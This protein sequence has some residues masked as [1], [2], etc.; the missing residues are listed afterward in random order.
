VSDFKRD[1]PDPQF[2][3]DADAVSVAWPCL[4]ACKD[5]IRN[6]AIVTANGIAL[7]AAL[8]YRP[9]A[10]EAT[11]ELAVSEAMNWLQVHGF[12]VERVARG[13][14]QPGLTLSR[15]ANSLDD[16]EQF[17]RSARQS[18]IDPSFLHPALLTAPLKNFISGEFDTAIYQ[19]FKAVEKSV[20][21]SSG[22]PP[23][24]YGS[25]MIE[26]AFKPKLGPLANTSLDEQE[27]RGEQSLMVGAFKRYRNASGH[28][29]SGIDDIV[30]V[31]EILALASLCL[32]IIDRNAALRRPSP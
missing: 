18:Y 32:R 1:F 14:Y 22:L 20:R 16:H 9:S 11:I 23:H 13:A 27:Q 19:A 10:K 4:R 21:T 3:I 24:S 26:T 30:E 28:R 5:G 2:L 8:E 31:A 29:D 6:N 7:G 12:L 17:R 15:L 25:G